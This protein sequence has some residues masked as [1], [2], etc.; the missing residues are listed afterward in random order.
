MC[1]LSE[2]EAYLAA[3]REE[4]CSR[5]IDCLPGVP[6]CEIKGERCCV[7][8]YLSRL[9][10]IYHTTD[11][12]LIDPYRDRFHKEICAGCELRSTNPCPCPL[13]YLLSLAV[14]A[15][16]AVDRRRSEHITDDWQI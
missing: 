5:C 7:E 16:E 6:P 10:E 9:V 13:Y 11:S 4:V 14:E 12:C 1:D 2:P 8:Q 15:I 3:V